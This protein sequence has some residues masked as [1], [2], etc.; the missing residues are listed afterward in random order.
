MAGHIRRRGKQSW[1]LKFDTGPDAV[2]GKRRIR[3][4]SFKGTKKDAQVE[5]A[6]LVAAH[7][8][9]DSVDPSK[10]TVAEFLD[11]W[12]RDWASS[13]VS[14]KTFERYSELLRNHVRPHIG[15][16][17]IQKLR[18][19]QLAELYGTLSS[20]SG[21]AARTI[22]HVHRVLHRALGHAAQWDVVHR[23]VA[24]RVSPPPVQATEISILKSDDVQRVLQ[25]LRGRT[26]YPIVATALGTGIRRGE[27][28]ALRWQDVDLDKGT[29]RIERS[30][31]ITKAGMR[32]KAP[33]TAHGRRSISLPPSLVSELRTHWKAQQE[34]RLALGLGKAPGDSLVFA[35]WEGNTRNPDGLTKEFSLAMAALGKPEITFHSLRHTHASQLIAAGLD[36]VTISRRLGHGSPA[37]TLRVYSHLFSNTDDRAAQIME[38]A[39]ASIRTE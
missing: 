23:N 34:Q 24:E 14:P 28:L 32:F 30:L 22:G 2:T 4:Q 31:E 16:V 19:V 12:E 1:E 15:S 6:K 33:K 18:P 27:L 10:L 3:Y 25:S 38:A 9:G 20:K 11:R 36:V 37:I 8:T 39:F 29:L 5:L 17:A 35:T 7:S 21:L 26:L 13:N